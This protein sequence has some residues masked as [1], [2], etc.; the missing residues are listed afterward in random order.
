MP[1]QNYGLL[2]GTVTNMM[3]S[4]AA[5]EKDPSG[6][7]HYH[8]EVS[9]GG[10]LYRAAVNVL[11]DNNP[12]DLQFYMDDNFQHPVLQTIQ[13]FSA[14][15]RNLQSIAGSGALD[16]VQGNLFDMSKM[17]IIPPMDGPGGRDLDDIMNQCFGQAQSTTGA[18]VYFFGTGFYDQGQSDDYFGFKPECGIHNIHMNQGSTGKFADENGSY[19]DGGIFL[20][21]PGKGSWT[22]MFFKFQ[23]QVVNAQPSAAPQH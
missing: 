4:V 23:S 8:V 12:P 15:Y 1:I 9:A 20:Y 21:Y 19:Q 14:G 11:S 5:A 7:P 18:M 10:Q 16:Y 22:A 13:G 6:K 3:D 2:A 17:S